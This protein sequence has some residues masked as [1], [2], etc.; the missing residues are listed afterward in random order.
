MSTLTSGP[1][2]L[3]ETWRL[4]PER[5]IDIKKQVMNSKQLYP[6]LDDIGYAFLR[7]LVLDSR[8]IHTINYVDDP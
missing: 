8:T 7:I 4:Y 5:I 6:T 2:P 3:Q 1:T